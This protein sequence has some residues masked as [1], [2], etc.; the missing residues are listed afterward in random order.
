MERPDLIV[1]CDIKH[2]EEKKFNPG[3]VLSCA[4][5]QRQPRV[6]AT[7]LGA[8]NAKPLSYMHASSGTTPPSTICIHVKWID[9][10]DPLD[11]SKE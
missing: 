10:T 11:I 5:T 9:E 6:D 7:M 1:N 2:F 4:T 3:F 8:A